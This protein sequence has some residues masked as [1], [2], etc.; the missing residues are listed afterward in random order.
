M[1]YKKGVLKKFGNFKG[2]NRCWS[3]LLIKFLKKTL[4]HRCF[5]VEFA[6]ILRTATYFEEHL[7]TTVSENT[8]TGTIEFHLKVFCICIF[9]IF[10]SGQ[11]IPAWYTPT[12]LEEWIFIIYESAGRDTARQFSASIKIN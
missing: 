9:Q 5:L 1:F 4:R 10:Y 7:C 11:Y 12:N 2:E 6:K 8:S 3:L